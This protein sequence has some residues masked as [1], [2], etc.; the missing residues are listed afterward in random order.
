MPSSLI[1][2]LK[3]IFIYLFIYLC[4]Y[5][6][7]QDCGSQRTTWKRPFSPFTPWVLRIELILCSLAASTVSPWVISLAPSS[8]SW[9]FIPMAQLGFKSNSHLIRAQGR[10]G[11]VCGASYRKSTFS[12]L[13]K[14]P[15]FD[16]FKDVM[17]SSTSDMYLNYL[18]CGW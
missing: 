17:I 16:T 2:T 14:V 3:I 4:V 10:Y 15:S 7:W 8:L 9:K 18:T 1:F 11:I 13:Q 12:G 6:P 5:L